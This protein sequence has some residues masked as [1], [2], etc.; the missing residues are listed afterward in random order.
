[1]TPLRLLNCQTTLG[2]EAGRRLISADPRYHSAHDFARNERVGDSW[3]PGKSNDVVVVTFAA[4]G[5]VQDD[6]MC[7]LQG[8]AGIHTASQVLVADDASY[9]SDSGEIDANVDVRVRP[10]ASLP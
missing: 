3:R 4:S 7:R 1:M 5:I 2:P 8:N 10:V 9:H 6:R